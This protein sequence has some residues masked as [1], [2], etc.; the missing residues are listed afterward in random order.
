MINAVFYIIAII[1]LVCAFADDKKVVLHFYKPKK[2]KI[3]R[4]K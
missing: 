3:R 4:L 2:T 1:V